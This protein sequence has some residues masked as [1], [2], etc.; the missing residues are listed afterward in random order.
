MLHQ[1]QQQ[2]QARSGQL[3]IPCWQLLLI[4]AVMAVCTCCT[5]ISATAVE[6]SQAMQAVGELMQQ[7]VDHSRLRQECVKALMGGQ[8]EQLIGCRPPDVWVEGGGAENGLQLL[9]IFLTAAAPTT[10]SQGPD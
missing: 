5:G 2:V 9:H 1:A 8:A 4:C 6:E 7:G 10:S 3:H